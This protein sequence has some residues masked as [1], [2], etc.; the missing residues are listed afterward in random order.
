MKKIALMA[1][2]L[3]ALSTAAM[4]EGDIKAGKKVFK[5]CKACHSLKPADNKVG[6]TLFNIIDAASGA[7][8]DFRYSKAMAEAGLT[9]D[10]ETLSAFLTKPKDVVPR[11]SMAFSGL[12]KPEQVDD[13]IAY[14]QSEMEAE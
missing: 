11:T 13:L 10:V 1:A 9:W 14:L 8:P 7:N 4:A 12:K 2:A 5:K 6:P 3:A